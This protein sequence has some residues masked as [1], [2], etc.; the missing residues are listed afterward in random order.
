[1][2]THSVARELIVI[3]PCL[4]SAEITS[5]IPNLTA[6]KFKILIFS[7]LCDFQAALASEAVRKH[8]PQAGGSRAQSVMSVAEVQG[9]PAFSP[10]DLIF[11]TCLS[12]LDKPPSFLVK[13]SEL[14]W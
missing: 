6:P 7:A 5:Q 8:Q 9:H 12:D 3:L 10:G 11:G 2:V 1:M 4:S 13:G 14:E